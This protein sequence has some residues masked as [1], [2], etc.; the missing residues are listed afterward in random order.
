VADLHAIV[1]GDRRTRQSTLLH[2][3]L[4]L[5]GPIPAGSMFPNECR[6]YLTGVM[7]QGVQF[8][9][10]LRSGLLPVGRRES[11]KRRRGAASGGPEEDAVHFVFTCGALHAARDQL[12]DAL[13]SITSGA[14][15]QHLYDEPLD[16]VL[17]S[18]L[19]NDSYWG[20]TAGV[21]DSCVRSFLVA[22]WAE[23]AVA[24][25][26]LDVGPEMLVAP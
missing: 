21:V 8:K 4:Q 24:A 6:P 2:K 13:D 16:Q 20:T 9:F 7:S 25:R 1:L 14:F 15:G 17:L 12:H 18:L 23:A 5:I 11:Q 26:G 3:Y 19:G 10:L 22:A